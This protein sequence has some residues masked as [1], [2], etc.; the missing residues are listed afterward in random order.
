[1]FYNKKIFK[2]CFCYRGRYWYKNIKRIPLYFKL[3]H[4][5]V[6]YGYDE[7][8]TWETFDWFIY[9]MKEILKTYREGHIGYPVAS[10]DDAELQKSANIAYDADIDK[11]I[12]LLDKMDEEYYSNVEYSNDYR[13]VSK[14]M[15]EAKDEFFQLFSKHF[16]SLWD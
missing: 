4:H 15:D 1:M 6:K 7:Y 12:A 5:L 8:A 11:M 13:R 3:M 10:F 9:T 14:E 16:Y 2:R